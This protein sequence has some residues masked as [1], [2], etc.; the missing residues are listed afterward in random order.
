MT[1]LKTR[2]AFLPAPPYDLE[3]NDDLVYENDR[4]IIRVYKG[5]KS[6]G[7]IPRF[8]WSWLGVTPTDPR[9][10]YAFCVHDFLYQSELTDR[11]TADNILYEILCIPPRCNLVQRRLI[12]RAVR[13]FGWLAYRSHTAQSIE[14][15]RKFGEVHEKKK[16]GT[17]IK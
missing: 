14:E 17:V 7:S 4:Y 15:G 9:C 13:T 2:P 6:S 11:T 5:Y 3:L 10:V 12:Y 16:L 8:C 1:E